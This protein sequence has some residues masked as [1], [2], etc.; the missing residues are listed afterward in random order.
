MPRRSTQTAPAPI[1]N[2]D[3]EALERD[4]KA[5]DKER[6]RL[7]VI[8]AEFG[9]GLPYNRDRLIGE[10]RFYLQQSADAMLEGGRKLILI[11]EHEPHG[12]FQE[13]VERIG[14]APRT[15]R[16]MMQ[17]AAKFRGN[18]SKLVNLGKTKLIELMV[19][20]DEDL[21]ELAEGGTLAGHSLDEIDR[22][23]A[24]DLRA[25]LRKAREKHRE[26]AEIHDKMLE[27]KDRKLNELDKRLSA[28]DRLPTWPAL[29]SKNLAETSVTAGQALQAMDKLDL[30]RD[31]IAMASAG[32]D[33]VHAS[34]A[35]A[36]TFIEAMAVPYLN[37]V[38]QV[39]AQAGELMYAAEEL[40]QGYADRQVERELNAP[41][42]EEQQTTH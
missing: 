2:I 31:R 5:L 42:D 8:D 39:W 11:K 29:V 9:D 15:A 13:I 23:T 4:A 24:T 19:E 3:T 16:R 25:A 7:M 40:F 21:D 33:E 32:E 26:E 17:A 1:D 12:D 35:E 18:K 28:L 10:C 34:D 27:Q 30:L 20:D 6:R 38:R 14:L 41:K 37:A 22:M 36:D